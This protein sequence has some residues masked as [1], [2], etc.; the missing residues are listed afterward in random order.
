[1]RS[2]KDLKYGEYVLTLMGNGTSL[3]NEAF[4]VVVK[5]KDQILS[6]CKCGSTKTSFKITVNIINFF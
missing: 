1:M 2:L 6:Y 4:T 3:Y 5:T